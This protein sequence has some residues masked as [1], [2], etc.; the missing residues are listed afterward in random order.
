MTRLNY[1][2]RHLFP[3]LIVVLAV[4]AGGGL[5]LQA[6]EDSSAFG[7]TEK[8]NSALIGIFYDLKQ[9]QKR[10]SV[11][12]DY[13]QTLGEFLKSG[14][15]E[16][17][18]RRY[19]RATRPIYAT[20][21]FIP[22]MGA[23]GAPKAFN[24]ENVVQPQQWFVVYKGQVSPPEDGTYRFVGTSD[25]V[26]A[27]AINGKTCL[28]SHFMGTTDTSNWKLPEP[29]TTVI[30]KVGPLRRGDWFECK[31][32][33]II[34]LDI[35]IGEY[36]GTAFG[37]WLFIEKKGSSYPTANGVPVLPVFQVAKQSISPER[38]PIPFSTDSAPWIC[39]Q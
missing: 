36:P 20:Q 3:A 27:V 11:N 14:W 33:Q 35:L 22:H 17:V 1:L 13:L 5:S 4:V 21:V 39:H 9:N 24:V 34:D 28:V 19:F 37:A 2:S 31:K 8:N 26:M 15:D 25:D 12:G 38:Q 23:G 6:A 10:E 16:N 7:S 29:T 32:D 18:L 30:T